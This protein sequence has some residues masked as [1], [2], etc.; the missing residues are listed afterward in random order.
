MDEFP[1]DEFLFLEP[2]EVF[3]GCLLGA[4]ERYDGL[5]V[6]AYDTR[7]VVAALGKQLDLS[8]EEALEFFE[9]NFLGAWLGEQ[10]PVYITPLWRES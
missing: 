7:R 6:S 5:V 9:F 2:A 1:D 10:T 8:P 3:D 4:A